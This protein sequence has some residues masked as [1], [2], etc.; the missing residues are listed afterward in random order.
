MTKRTCSVEGCERPHSGRGYCAVHYQHWYRWGDPLMWAPPRQTVCSF[1]GCD[2]PFESRGYCTGHARQLRSG[3]ELRP[4]RSFTRNGICSIDGCG[5]K[6]LAQGWCGLHYSRW[7]NYGDPLRERQPGERNKSYKRPYTLNEAFFDEVTTEAQAYW[8]GFITADGNVRTSPT[9]GS[10]LTV[11]LQ[12]GDRP[13]LE[14]LCQ[15]LGSNRPVGTYRTTSVAAFG[16]WRL[17][18]ALERLG[19]TPRKSGIVRPWP[20][21]PNLMSHYWR[22]LFDGDGSIS[23]AAKARCW[24]VSICGSKACVA[25]FATWGAE[26]CGSRAAI[27]PHSAAPACWYWTVGGNRMAALL[28]DGLYRDATVAL[29]RKQARAAQLCDEHL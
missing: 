21:P 5:R 23:K 15:D 16:S 6:L 13:H 17:V 11:E 2:K 28:A 26:I 25:D 18:E 3:E 8:L 20:G 4:L 12:T 14:R 22:G 9:K 24:S 19:V 10:T 7:K 29:A 27:R 1:P